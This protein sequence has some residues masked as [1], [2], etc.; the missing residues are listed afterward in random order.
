MALYRLSL[1]HGSRQTG[2]SASAKSAY[3]SRTGKYENQP[4]KCIHIGGSPP[5]P[6]FASM[7]NFWEMADKHERANARLFSE[8]KITIPVELK[9]EEQQIAAIKEYAETLLPN[10]PYTFAL[11]EGYGKNPHAHLIFSERVIDGVNRDPEKFF[12]RA[13]SKTPGKGG[14]MKNRELKNK[15]WL[16]GAREHWEDVANQHLKKAFKYN[17]LQKTPQISHKKTRDRDAPT[18]TGIN[19]VKRILEKELK[20]DVKGNEER[21]RR[22]VSRTVH[23]IAEFIRVE[24]RTERKEMGEGEKFLRER[25]KVLKEEY[26]RVAER[27]REV[28]RRGP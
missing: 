7:D 15:D 25:H 5:P 9:K 10:Q 23:E 11:H 16:K 18:A 6:G 1:S 2:Q 24:T 14:A 27:K 13:N 22:D 19:H 8:L 28:E 4:D 12:K 3:I 26:D 21:S 20:L 17:F